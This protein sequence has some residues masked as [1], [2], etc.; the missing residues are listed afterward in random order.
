MM[1]MMASLV[2]WRSN[3][4]PLF[5]PSPSI[6]TSWFSFSWFP[7]PLPFFYPPLTFFLLF[8]YPQI[9]HTA[10]IQS[11]DTG[12]SFLHD[13]VRTSAFSFC[14]LL[15]NGCVLGTL[16]HITSPFWFFIL[17]GCWIYLTGTYIIYHIPIWTWD[18]IGLELIFQEFV[19]VYHITL[20]YILLCL[21]FLPL[22]SLCLLSFCSLCWGRGCFNL[23]FATT[24]VSSVSIF[25]FVSFFHNSHAGHRPALLLSLAFLTFIYTSN[26]C[27][28]EGDFVYGIC[29]HLV[30]SHVCIL[31]LDGDTMKILHFTVPVVSLWLAVNHN[32][33]FLPA[34]FPSHFFLFSCCCCSFLG[35][36]YQPLV[37]HINPTPRWSF[38]DN[39]SAEDCPKWASVSIPAFESAEDMHRYLIP[40][41]SYWDSW[42]AVQILE[43][44][45]AHQRQEKVRNLASLL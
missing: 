3:S 18:G 7:P 21:S 28:G 1:T 39:F 30:L 8:S 31:W 9:P 23:D 44:S 16:Y 12:N 10:A 15:L 41:S 13:D 22:L 14:F 2:E 17:R 26:L 24:Y 45:A 32:W 37:E 40:Q 33:L 27:V 19:Q 6:F 35:H 20:Y 11:A 36:L 38:C 5:C 29:S 34:S 25:S 4:S 42:W 43:E